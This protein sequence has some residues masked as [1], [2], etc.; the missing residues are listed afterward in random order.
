MLELP[1]RGLP[2][3]GG[4]HERNLGH[5][6][7][8]PLN[9]PS[10]LSKPVLKLVAETV[11]MAPAH[12]SGSGP[13]IPISGLTTNQVYPLTHVFHAGWALCLGV[14]PIFFLS[15]TPAHLCCATAGQRD[16]WEHR[17]WGR[18]SGFGFWLRHS[19]AARPW[20]S[21]ITFHFCKIEIIAAPAC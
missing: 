2:L 15:K 1:I 13:R 3:T 17:P 19:I 6:P 7:L 20:P 4:R 18:T 16:G 11:H 21:H 14:L 12:L 9:F 10:L 5:L 8:A